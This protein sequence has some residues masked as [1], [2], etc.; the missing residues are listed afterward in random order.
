[1]AE[2][3]RTG[4]KTPKPT[5]K[6]GPNEEQSSIALAQF[7]HNAIAPVADEPEAFPV[8]PEADFNKSFCDHRPALASRQHP[9]AARAA[10]L[11]RSDRTGLK[12]NAEINEI[13]FQE[14]KQSKIF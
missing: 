14:I 13:H 3:A 12:S 10:L 2:S 5:Q 6:T 7:R 4:P 1:L 11:H 8:Q 9:P